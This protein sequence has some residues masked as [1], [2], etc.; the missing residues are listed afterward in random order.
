MLRFRSK[1]GFAYVAEDPKK[2]KFFFAKDKFRENV[3]DNI[4][5]NYILEIYFSSH[6]KRMQTKIMKSEQKQI[7]YDFDE[8]FSAYVSDD[9]KN[10]K[11]SNKKISRKNN[12]G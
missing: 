11:L 6:P 5:K 9:S 8:N 10:K 2:M 4:F 7:G 12:Y 3:F 1:L